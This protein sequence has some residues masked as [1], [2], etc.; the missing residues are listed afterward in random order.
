MSDKVFVD[1]NI[2][3]YARDTSAA[4]KHKKAREKVTELWRAA[5]GC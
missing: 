3:V 2:L 1:T 4:D 5:W